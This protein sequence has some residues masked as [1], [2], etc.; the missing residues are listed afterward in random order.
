MSLRSSRRRPRGLG[1]AARRR[2]SRR[3]VPMAPIAWQGLVFIGNAGGDR[4]GVIGHV[5]ALDAATGQVEW[6][7]D[8]VP[9]SGPARETWGRGAASAYPVSGGAFWT[10]FTLDEKAACCTCQRATQ[11]R[12]STRD[13]RRRELYANSSSR[14]TQLGR[15]LA[16]N[17]LV[18]HDFHD[19]DVDSPSPAGDDAIG[20]RR[21]GLGQ[22]GR[23]VV[24]G[25]SHGRVAGPRAAAA[26]AELPVLYRVA[27][28]TRENVDVPLS[29][30]H[31]TRF[32]P[33]SSAA[34]SGTARRTTRRATHSS[35]ARTIGADRATST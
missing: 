9:P 3:P 34:P 6:K 1:R 13:A 28:T 5:Y 8:V 17:Q 14:S 18:K 4:S 15:M 16:F 21:G 25:R 23:P 11:R 20:A 19:W 22:Q 32:C 33:A 2:G 30:D 26:P 24:G 31:P 27:T 12:I 10:S 7:F 35:S 29:R